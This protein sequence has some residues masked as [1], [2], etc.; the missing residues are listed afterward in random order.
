M[1]TVTLKILVLL[2]ALAL[3]ACS[4]SDSGTDNSETSGPEPGNA[5]DA[6]VSSD[7]STTVREDSS[8]GSQPDDGGSFALPDAEFGGTPPDA[9]DGAPS[10]APPDAGQ[11]GTGDGRGE[12][13][14]PI[15][16]GACPAGFGGDATLTNALGMS[17]EI[18]DVVLEASEDGPGYFGLGVRLEQWSPGIIVEM[19]VNH[20]GVAIAQA[21]FT[22]MNATCSSDGSWMISDLRMNP[23]PSV[24]IDD[25]IE[26]ELE[27]TGEVRSEVQDVPSIG[28]M[29]TIR[30][31]Y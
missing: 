27:V 24:E 28:I 13:D 23:L 25:I 8:P 29:G 18:L 2:S 5:T 16:G 20:G 15:G 11:D 9:S 1:K 3:G 17:G 30:L 10:N 19:N 7:V 6:N 14:G 31:Q 12:G 21:E 26:L 22:P 4:T